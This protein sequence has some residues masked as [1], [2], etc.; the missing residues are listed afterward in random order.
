MNIIL[1]GFMGCGK[2]AAGREIANRINMRFVDIDDVIEQ[3]DGRKISTIFSQDGEA[4]FRKLERE[5]VQEL[6]SLDQQVVATGGGVMLDPANVRALR[7][8]GIIVCLSARPEV[9]RA[10]VEGEYH[11]PLLAGDKG[12]TKKRIKVLLRKRAHFYRLA[13]TEVNTSNITISEVADLVVR[14]VAHEQLAVNLGERSYPIFVGASVK[15]T[16]K[17]ALEAGLTGKTLLVSDTNVYSLYGKIV[18]ES[19]ARS[20]FAVNV[21]QL[22]PGERQKSL[23]R[24]KQMYQACLEAGLNRSSCVI[25]LGGGVVGDLAGFVAA[26]FMRGVNFAIIPTS[27]LS[28]VDSSVGGKVA[29]NLPQGKNLVGTFHQPRF[30]LVDPL[31][32]RTLQPRRIREGLAE[33]IKCAVIANEELFCYLEEQMAAAHAGDIGILK[34]VALASIETKVAVVEADEREEKG[35]RQVLNLG[36]TLG[37][38]VEA[39]SRYGRFT[40]GEGVAVGMVA[41]FKIAVALGSCSRFSLR[42]V[43][44]LIAKAGLPTRAP[45]LNSQ[46]LFDRLRF[47]KKTR[48]GRLTFVLPLAVGSVCLRNDVPMS[49][50]RETI[51][52]IV[53]C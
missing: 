42:R 25:A 27:L 50:V 6:A 48:Q 7:S 4:H 28:Q 39:A 17:L 2:S 45:G 51:E 43:E 38:A 49:L 44:N 5:V 40:H 36:H 41:A 11:R 20:G 21:V 8:S 15:D 26:T 52:E 35:M 47:D 23:F 34:K 22:R 32:L 16:G 3:R 1:V 19:L 37:H 14:L 9:I 30:V 53:Q 33:A 13:D 31:V 12:F 46:D 18:Y 24:A 29:V 10:R